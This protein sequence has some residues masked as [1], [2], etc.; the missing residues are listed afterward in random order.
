[1]ARLISMST[2][3]RRGG[4]GTPYPK[5]AADAKRSDDELGSARQVPRSAP[6]QG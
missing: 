3:Y 2:W 4:F 1:V 6:G 5:P